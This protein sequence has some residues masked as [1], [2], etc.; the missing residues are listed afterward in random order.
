MN[1]CDEQEQLDERLVRM[2]RETGR[3]EDEYK[4]ST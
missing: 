1:K 2:E 4:L 3:C